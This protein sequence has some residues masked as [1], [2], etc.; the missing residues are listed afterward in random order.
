RLAPVT[1]ATFSSSLPIGPTPLCALSMHAWEQVSRRIATG[2]DEGR[3]HCAAGAVDTAH[4]NWNLAAR[5]RFSRSVPATASIARAAPRSEPEYTA[6]ET[7]RWR[8][9]RDRSQDSPH[10]PGE[11]SAVARRDRRPHRP[12]GDALLEAHSA[13]GT[14]RRD[15]QAGRAAGPG[16]D[17]R[18]RHRL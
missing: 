18:W 3:R 14:G 2:I 9:G 8:H 6:H 7:T 15:P 12:V 13:P 4:R 5:N 17:R 10:R 1:I 16:Q 11:L